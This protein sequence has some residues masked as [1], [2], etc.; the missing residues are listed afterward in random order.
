MVCQGRCPP[1]RQEQQACDENTEC[2]L[3]AMEKLHQPAMTVMNQESLTL[4]QP[5]TLFLVHHSFHK[6]QMV[7]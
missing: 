6:H 1:A 3:S 2:E 7:S 5:R 4:R